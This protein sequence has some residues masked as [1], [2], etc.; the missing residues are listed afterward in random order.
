LVDAD[1]AEQARAALRRHVIQPLMTRCVDRE[2]G[3]FLVDFDERWRAVGPHNKTLEH[4]SRMTMAFALLERVFPGE[5]CDRL[6]L[7]GC[8]FLQEVMWDAGHGGFFALVDRGG[9]PRW[10]GLKHPHAVTYAAEALALSAPLLPPGEGT[11]WAQR[12]LAW[13]D[14]VAWDPVDG[15]YW[16]SFRRDNERYPDG[17]RLPTPD[18]RDVLGSTPGFK[19]INTQGDAIEMLTALAEAR[20]G[21]SAERL[22]WLLDL[23]IDRLDDRSGVLAYLYRRDWRPVPDLA[24]IGYHFQLAHRLLAALP[25]GGPAAVARGCQ[26]IDFALRA[27]RHPGGGFCYAVTADGRVWPAIGPASDSRQWWVQIEAAR[28]LH[29]FANHGAV[30]DDRRAHYRRARDEQWAFVRDEFFDL[31]YGGIREVPAEPGSRGLAQLCRW[32]RPSA[33]IRRMKTHGWK[34]AFHEVSAFVALGA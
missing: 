16:G 3:G 30:D 18:G 15:G 20:V 1:V 33:S 10:D 25:R 21:G 6:A 26:L 14:E 5:G 7:H 32:L 17:A 28:A 2:Y 9:R 4:A 29:V 8:A 23:V 22:A 11:V 12:A 34:D 24:R 13:L 27:A 19:E 31:R